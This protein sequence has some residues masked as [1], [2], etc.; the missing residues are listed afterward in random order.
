MYVADTTPRTG[1]PNDVV[2]YSDEVASI[3]DVEFEKG[4]RLCAL[5]RRP[6]GVLDY[7]RC[8]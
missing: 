7:F 4:E 8:I 3:Y 2:H 5:H 6:D 1:F